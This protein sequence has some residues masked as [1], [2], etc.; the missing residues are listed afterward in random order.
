MVFAST[1]ENAGS[2]PWSP[3]STQFCF[4]LCNI[5]ECSFAASA[6]S[7]KSTLPISSQLLGKQSHLQSQEKQRITQVEHRT[8][9]HNEY[10]YAS[11]AENKAKLR[12]TKALSALYCSKFRAKE[13][14]GKMVFRFLKVS[15]RSQKNFCKKR[16]I[17]NSKTGLNET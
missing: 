11:R 12:S 3:E 4:H 16:K 6:I 17:F 1:T 14:N 13:S 8:T 2:I 15:Q 9:S 10:F 5:P 7:P